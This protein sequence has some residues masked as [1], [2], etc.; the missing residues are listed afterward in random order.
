MSAVRSAV[1]HVFLAFGVLLIAGCGDD[2]TNRSITGTVTRGGRPLPK[3]VVQFFP[4]A[5]Q[6]VVATIDDS[7]KYLVELPPGDYEV[8]INT[9]SGLPPGWKEGDLIPQQ[10]LVI[11]VE[12]TT[13]ARTPL[14]A[15]VAADQTEPID[16]VL[17]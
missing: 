1:A 8:T 5:G 6:T 11:P 17:P 4:A 2:A 10:E 16:F 9:N 7:G 15:T 13:R 12:Y 3:C 14:K